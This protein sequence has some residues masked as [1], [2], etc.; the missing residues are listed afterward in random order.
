MKKQ[1]ISFNLMIDESGDTTNLKDTPLNRA[2]GALVFFQDYTNLES[3]FLQFVNNT[4]SLKYFIDNKPHDLKFETL[5]KQQN[6]EELFELILNFL[7]KKGC[8]F[9]WHPI[10][11][12]NKRHQ[13]K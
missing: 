11:E 5:N 7:I 4:P 1:E 12:Q 6:S 9:Y 10:K 2:V 8:K 13:K 3:D